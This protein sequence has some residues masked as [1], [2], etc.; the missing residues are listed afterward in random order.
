M[1]K[2]DIRMA[3]IMVPTQ[4]SACTAVLCTDKVHLEAL[5]WYCAGVMEGIQDSAEDSLPVPS[6]TC[7]ELKKKVT[8]GLRSQVQPVKDTAYVCHSVWKSAGRPL[9]CQLH[10]IMKRTRNRYHMEF[11]KCQKAEKSIKK[12]KILEAC[13]NGQA[14]LFK[15]IKAM[16]KTV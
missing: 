6:V 15:E 10:T 16:R 3:S 2:L 4:V 5:D 11:K 8:T 13:L 1:Y 14:E 9:D 12:S 7:L